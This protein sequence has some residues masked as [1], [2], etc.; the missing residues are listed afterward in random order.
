MCCEQQFHASA[1]EILDRRHRSGR[2]LGK[3]LDGS[4]DLNTAKRFS[5]MIAILAGAG[6]LCVVGC[7]D[8]S[9]R[10]VSNDAGSGVVLVT[11][12][13][14]LR[15]YSSSCEAEWTEPVQ[16]P[17]NLPPEATKLLTQQPRDGTK[18]WLRQPPKGIWLPNGTK[19]NM[20]DR[21]FLRRG[22]LVDPYSANSYD[23]ERDRAVEVVLFR[24]K[25]GP[26]KDLEGWM[27]NRYLRPTVMMP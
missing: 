18:T 27:P 17:P 22:Q 24:V 3:R 4:C 26:H 7:G 11:D 15:G 14:V 12:E 9:E 16:I 8:I 13:A 6:T 21:K 19:G 2:A 23:M 20:R 25:D 1:M 5:P 10:V